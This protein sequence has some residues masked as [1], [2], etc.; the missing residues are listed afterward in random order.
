MTA[1][2]IRRIFLLIPTLLGITAVVFFTMKAAPGDVAELLLSREGYMQAGDRQA[3][4]DYIRTRYGLDDP[5]IVQYGR[6]LHNVSPV[7]VFGPDTAGF[8]IPIGHDD[9]GSARYLGIK[10]PDLGHSF[11]KQRPVTDL[12]TQAMPITIMLNL[13]S[14]PVIYLMAIVSGVYAA[15]HRGGSF[16]LVSGFFYLALWSVPVIWAG[17]MLQGFF[18]NEQYLR[19][20]P[21]TGL[22]SLMADSM[23]FL[24]GFNDA[25]FQ[26][27]YLLDTLWHV[28]LPVLCLAYTALAFMSKL[29]RGAV[30]EVL[31][32]DYIR[33]AR[34]KGLADRDVL[35]RHAFR[36]S[37]LP[38]ITVAAFVIPGLIG[39][40][41]VV[42]YIF[43]INGMGKL[44]IESI[45]FKDQE[46]VMAVTL[47]GGVLS[48]AAYLVADLLYAVAD[49]RVTY[50]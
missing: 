39:G 33:T 26:C 34:A 21:T 9:A 11:I 46:V 8:G 38:L 42:E 43:G 27:G 41:V 40:S 3:R 23:T 29:S 6:W 24:P 1:Y 25:G 20:F 22:H 19:I 50:E 12:L 44:M 35:W 7:G 47:L 30:L 16:D 48:L 15:R 45:K 28:A 18:A 17:T 5:A 37:L 10:K 32:S 14:I 4:L 36:N 49:P 2:F 31:S 13:L